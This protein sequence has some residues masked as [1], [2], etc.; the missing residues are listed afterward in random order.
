MN[1]SFS[2][3]SLAEPLTRGLDKLGIATPT[4]VQRQAIPSALEGRD[5][6]VCAAT[7]SGKTLAFLLP[8]MQRFVEHPAPSNG[9][10][11]LI[12][13]PTRELARQ[14][15]AHFL[16]VGSYTR[17]TAEI[18][19]GGTPGSHQVAA[20]RKNPDVL[21]AT[22]GRLL[23]HLERGTADLSDLEVLVLDEADRMLD[24]GFAVEVT[25][26]IGRCNAERQ[27]LLFSAT[28]NRRGLQPITNALL[29]DP[30]PIAVDH[31]RSAHPSIRH[32]ILLAD[33]PAH[34]RELL[35]AVLDDSDADR[36]LVFTNTRER[37][38]NL[39]AELLS[40]GQ[41]TAALHGKLDQRE[42]NRVLDLLRRGDIRVLVATDLASRGLDLPGTDLV[43]NFEVPRSGGDYLHRTGRTGRAGASGLAISLVGAP[44]WN[45]MESIVRYLG[46]DP[47][48]RT[49]EGLEAKY[50]GP[51]RPS[52]SKKRPAAGKG[53]AKTVTRV[54][55]R[56]RDR[57]KIGKRRKPSS[58]AADQATDAGFEPLFK[59]S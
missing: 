55:E 51:R 28:L 25:Q 14:I 54:K 32:Q 46:L 16:Q 22:P 11:A 58:A 35:A 19:V 43:V 47:E 18:I 56:H 33:D 45:R 8:M 52:R 59:K 7:G 23:E 41:R 44:E 6:L 31:H 42:R 5:L 4:P 57:K 20:L 38:V 39:A 24:M 2:D 1:D 13:A 21:I 3:F 34:K 50:R 53:K 9:T 27:S 37:A 15:E 30:V 48:R 10:R 26:I 36:S 40:R 49:V 17:L 29:R 12:L